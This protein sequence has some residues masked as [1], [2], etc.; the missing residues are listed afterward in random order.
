[1][2]QA[3]EHKIP[4]TRLD[5]TVARL[6]LEDAAALVEAGSAVED[7]ATAACKGSWVEW[8]GWVLTMLRGERT[9]C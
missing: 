7:A 2:E 4:T 6:A 1:M 8:R 5:K 9:A 3:T